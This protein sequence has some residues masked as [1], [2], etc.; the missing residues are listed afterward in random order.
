MC[1]PLVMEM[2]TKIKDEALYVVGSGLP[3]L[4]LLVS[5]EDADNKERAELMSGII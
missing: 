2:Y 1:V 4:G 3:N 5:D